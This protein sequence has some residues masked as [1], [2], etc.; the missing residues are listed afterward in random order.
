ME[1]KELDRHSFEIQ[2]KE[3]A[4][5]AN[6]NDALEADNLKLKDFIKKQGVK[7]KYKLGLTR[8]TSKKSLRY[9]C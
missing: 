3:L 5:R 1:K 6:Q 9:G 7:F 8:R 4:Q 2:I